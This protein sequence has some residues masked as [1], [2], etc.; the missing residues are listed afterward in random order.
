MKRHVLWSRYTTCKYK[1]VFITVTILLNSFFGSFAFSQRYDILLNDGHVID[2]ANNINDV[3]DIAVKDGKIARIEKNISTSGA[4]KVVDVSGY[5]VTPGLVDMH[6]VCFHTAPLDYVRSV[7]ADI[8]CFPSGV[9]T[10]VDGGTSGADTF[11][12]FKKIIDISRPR[13]LAFINI[14]APGASRVKKDPA[15]Y[16][17]ESAVAMAKKYPDIIVG[18]KAAHFQEIDDNSRDP[19]TSVEKALSMGRLSGL[20]VMFDFEPKPSRGGFPERSYRE[21]LL[22]RARPGDIVTHCYA[23]RYPVILKD[24]RLNPDVLSAQK[25][26]I[27]FDLGHAGRSFVYRAIVPAIE[28]GFLPDAISSALFDITPSTV[29]INLTN[30]MSKFLSM[31][32][33]FEDIIRRTTVN[34]AQIINHTELGTLSV[35]ANADIAVL[36]IIKGNFAYAG[37]SY[38]GKGGGKITGDKKIQC[39]MTLFGG[40]IVYDHPYGLSLPLWE[41]I[42]KDSEYWINPEYKQDWR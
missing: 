7:I 31:G 25:H 8:H 21:F 41:D 5:Y 29:G 14:S 12:E 10:C 20:P 19:W 11:E 13:I 35:G 18:F 38:R 34:P 36:E 1:I 30:I 22:R 42:P 40:E 4:E 2:P 28:Q 39:V 24:G 26:G 6:I 16:N 9:T 33:P 23:L 15:L 32:V 17:V 37:T 27:T 3:M